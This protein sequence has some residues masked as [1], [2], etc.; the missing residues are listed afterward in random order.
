MGHRIIVSSINLIA[1]RIGR[2]SFPIRSFHA[3]NSAL[4]HEKEI[5]LYSNKKQTPVTLKS[6][7]ETGKGE[8]LSMDEKIAESGSAVTSKV[9]V[10]VACFLHR[11]LPVRLAHRAMKLEASPLFMKSGKIVNSSFLMTPLLLMHAPLFET[12]FRAYS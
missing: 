4:A 7:V 2:V 9:L 1:I 5:L 8:R 6:L 12:N 3:E 11:E 10:Q